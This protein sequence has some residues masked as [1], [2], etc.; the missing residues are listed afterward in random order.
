MNRTGGRQSARIQIKCLDANHSRI[1]IEIRLQKLTNRLRGEVPASRNRNVR[2]PWTQFWLDA[3]G[4]RG[5]LHA[6]VYLEKM[7]MSATNADPNDFRRA[8]RRKCAHAG[9]R[10]K[11]RPKLDCPEFF[12]QHEID[13]LSNVAEEAQ[14]Q[15][16]LFGIDPTHSANLWIKIDQEV[17]A[18]FRQINRDKQAF[19]HVPSQP[20]ISHR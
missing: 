15:M 9:D 17:F 19:G 7:W 5:L 20:Q 6:F 18:E 8:L 12:A 1:K 10:Q 2:M 13:I 14:G 16:H 3:D 11:K 4:Q